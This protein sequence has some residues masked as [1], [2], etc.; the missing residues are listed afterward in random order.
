MKITPTR[1]AINQ[2]NEAR[3]LIVA[4]HTKRARRKLRSARRK[5]AGLTGRGRVADRLLGQALEHLID[6]EHGSACDKARAAVDC[7]I[8]V[9]S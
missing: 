4:G 8:G 9:M 5:M 7:L 6:R 2:A 1:I 3:S